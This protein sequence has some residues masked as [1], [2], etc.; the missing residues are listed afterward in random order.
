MPIRLKELYVTSFSYYLK[1]LK[2][3]L[4]DIPEIDERVGIIFI[5]NFSATKP[6]P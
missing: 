6:Q 3:T 5:Y 2:N 4:E 1:I